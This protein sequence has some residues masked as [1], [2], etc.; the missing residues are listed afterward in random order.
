MFWGRPRAMPPW[1]ESSEREM[2]TVP[3]DDRHAFS[4]MGVDVA[5]Q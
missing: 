3:R 4:V 2:R 5:E 1:L